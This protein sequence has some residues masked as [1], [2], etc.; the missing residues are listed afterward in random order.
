MKRRVCFVVASEMTVRAFLRSH[1]RAMQSDY[2]ITIVVNTSNDR[3]LR[4]LGV[5]GTLAPVRIERRISPWRDLGALAALY[6]LLR[7]GRFDI[8]HS[9]TPKAGLLAMTAAWIARTPVRIHTFTGQVWATK[10]GPARA[11]LR[12]LD[13]ILV[14]MGTVTI[15]DSPSQREFLIREG[16]AS[17][18]SLTVLE[19]GSI[20]GVDT[21]T[22]RPDGAARRAV[23]DRLNIPPADVLLLF[24]GRLT[25]DKGVLD[26]AEA[27][28]TIA[29]ERPDVR[30][31]FAGPDEAGLRDAIAAASAP[32]ANRVHFLEFTDRPQDVM[33]AADVLCLP[34]YREGFGSVI[35]E[36]A[37]CEVPS[38]A[39]RIYGVVDAVD[40]GRTG[41]LHAAGD[42]SGLAE[43]L[44]RLTVDPALRQSFGAA[45]R[46]RVERDFPVGRLTAALIALYS[47]LLP[48]DPRAGRSG[49]PSRLRRFGMTGWY[50]RFGKRLF[51]LTVTAFA[52]VLLSPLL[53]VLAILVR[54]TLGSPVFFR[55][56][57][58]GLHGAPFILVKFRSM[59]YRYDEAGG[60]LPDGQRLTRIGRFLRATSL[61]ELPELW[62]VLS[63]DMS[64]VG[65]RPL[66][67]EYLP[68][69][70]ARHAARH[71]VR[72]GITG[73][74]QVSGRNDLPWEE[75]FELD[76]RYAERV[77]LTM[78]LSIL[79]RTV[80]LV[81]ERRGISQPGHA[82]AQKF[83]GMESQ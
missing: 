3:L 5:E 8:V 63:G 28:H 26:L 53:A 49:S 48:S 79:A 30:L 6:R 15:A 55:Q 83:N 68:R 61:D 34:S 82:T 31:L 14:R 59:T 23:R 4:D 78:D 76:L 24:V 38:V 51:D 73:L 41:L 19:G 60:R 39:S 37:A 2:D 57:R 21:A 25:T 67:M 17:A 33:A 10:R 44:R 54:T 40:D 81:I 22:F 43:Q 36:A 29:S 47:E 32:H 12:A 69:Y 50:A 46:R 16:V 13:A 11:I 7:S 72:P 65:P 1:L 9:V 45:A 71:T 18:S 66:L 62:N 35:I 75:R 27:F 80:W 56:G 20:S 58:P 70:S 42:V 64:L 74:A 77:S 52:L